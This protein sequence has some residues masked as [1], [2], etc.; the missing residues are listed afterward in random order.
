MDP[1][2]TVVE[3]MAEKLSRAGEASEEAFELEE[4]AR[5]RRQISLN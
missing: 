1:T 5:C 4:A 2:A 3:A